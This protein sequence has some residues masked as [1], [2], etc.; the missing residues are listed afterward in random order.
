MG[1][2]PL[3]PT[4]FCTPPLLPAAPSPVVFPAAPSPVPFPVCDCPL[5]VLPLWPTFPHFVHVT[6]FHFVDTPSSSVADLLLF[7]FWSA[8]RDTILWW[9]QL[10]R[11]C[12]F[13]PQKPPI[14]RFNFEDIHFFPSLEPICWVNSCLMY[15]NIFIVEPHIPYSCYTMFAG[16]ACQFPPVT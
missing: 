16:Y 15:S 9:Y 10:G 2:F 14:N 3:F 13:F 12:A 7:F 8:N 6:D 4:P 5:Q 1:L 11:T